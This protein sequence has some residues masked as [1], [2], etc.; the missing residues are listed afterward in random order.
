M[1]DSCLLLNAL[2]AE[3]APIVF[4]AF[5]FVVVMIGE[6]ADCHLPMGEACKE[7]VEKFGAH[8]P[9]YADLIESTYF[10]SAFSQAVLISLSHSSESSSVI[11]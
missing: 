8:I 1:G 7:V 11:G 9:P 3:I 5:A 2:V 6:A 10:P 4:H